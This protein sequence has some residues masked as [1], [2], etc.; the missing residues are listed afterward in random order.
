MSGCVEEE[1]GQIPLGSGSL[2]SVE[3]DFST[4]VPAKRHRD[5]SCICWC[6]WSV[7]VPWVPE[8]GQG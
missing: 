2:S 1:F 6:H 8:D 4:T 5:W 3:L 7:A